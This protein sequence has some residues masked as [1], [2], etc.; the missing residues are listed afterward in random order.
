MEMFYLS[1][2]VVGVGAFKEAT[3]AVVETDGDVCSLLAQM[4]L[5]ILDLDS[6]TFEE[7]VTEA[8]KQNVRQDVSGSLKVS[9]FSPKA[10]ELLIV[11]VDLD[12]AT[13]MSLVDKGPVKIE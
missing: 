8:I 10:R 4:K 2:E 7:K 3:R 9:V 11:V 1:W 6:R 5:D 12:E 13:T